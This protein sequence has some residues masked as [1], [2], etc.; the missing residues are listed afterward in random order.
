MDSATQ[1]MRYPAG[2]ADLLWVM[3]KR[4]QERRDRLERYLCHLEKHFEEVESNWE[5]TLLEVQ[6]S[7]GKR[8][9]PICQYLEYQAEG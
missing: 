6:Q 9:R 3:I 7:L 5:N 2:L 1:S 8:G 4:E